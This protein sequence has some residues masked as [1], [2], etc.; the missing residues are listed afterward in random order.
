MSSR[1]LGGPMSSRTLGGWFHSPASV[2]LGVTLTA[3]ASQPSH[4]QVWGSCSDTRRAS[5]ARV[6]QFYV[7]TRRRRLFDIIHR[8][9]KLRRRK[10]IS[11]QI[12]GGGNP[13]LRLLK[14]IKLLNY[15]YQYFKTCTESGGGWGQQIEKKEEEEFPL[16]LWVSSNTSFTHHLKTNTNTILGDGWNKYWSLFPPPIPIPGVSK[17]LLS[18]GKTSTK[19]HMLDEF[20]CVLWNKLKKH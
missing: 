5:H 19:T 17:S 14:S 10:H 16:C 3:W 13:K 1:T 9:R 18:G 15:L 8:N 11:P 7:L 2:A 20:R 12:W 4:S 6:M